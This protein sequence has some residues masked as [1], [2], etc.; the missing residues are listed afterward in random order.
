MPKILSNR[1]QNKGFMSWQKWGIPR[2]HCSSAPLWLHKCE[3]EFLL[4]K[5]ALLYVWWL[6]YLAAAFHSQP[7]SYCSDQPTLELFSLIFTSS[8]AHVTVHSRLC[9][10]CFC[11]PLWQY[12]YCL[13]YRIWITSIT[14]Y[15]FQSERWSTSCDHFKSIIDMRIIHAY[16][17][18][19]SRG[20]SK[21][22]EWCC[23]RDTVTTLSSRK[24]Q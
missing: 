15:A 7:P 1:N 14:C 4:K 22:T 19:R 17:M 10:L 23:N 13:D 8:Y 9:F 24:V 20:Y 16:K 6:T 11:W 3:G 5:V 12:S 21:G 2:P 18:S